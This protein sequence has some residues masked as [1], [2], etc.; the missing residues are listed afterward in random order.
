[1][2]VRF[3]NGQT[4]FQHS[5]GLTAFAAM[6][7]P[8]EQLEALGGELAGAALKLPADTEIVRPPAGALARL[9]R[10]HA[11]ASTLAKDNPAVIADPRSAAALEQALLSAMVACLVKGDVYGDSAASRHHSMIVRRFHEL[12]EASGEERLPIVELCRKLHVSDRT[13]RACCQEHLGMAPHRYLWMRQM[14]ITRRALLR[15]SPV[16]TTVTDIAT[17]N[18]FW[19]LGRFA[20][21]YRQ[22]FGE[23]PSA[24]LRRLPQ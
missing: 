2:L 20:V 13:L 17:A 12:L 9:R 1:V 24:S 21:G 15:A 22:L 5:T 8:I 6:S 16:S 7:L 23:S 4:C 14:T 10:L 19:E 11:A 3:A 18:G